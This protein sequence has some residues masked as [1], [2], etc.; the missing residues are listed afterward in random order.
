MSTDL[1]IDWTKFDCVLKEILELQAGF[2]SVMD[3]SPLIT[4][5]CLLRKPSQSFQTGRVHWIVDTIDSYTTR[6]SYSKLSSAAVSFCQH[7]DQD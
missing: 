1:S 6:I 7:Q 2:R 3:A 5:L 4:V